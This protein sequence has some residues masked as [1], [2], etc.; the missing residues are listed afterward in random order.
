MELLFTATTPAGAR[1]DLQV[2]VDDGAATGDLAEAL[3]EAL[4][5]QRRPAALSCERLGGAVPT[6]LRLGSAGLLDGDVLSLGD[7]VGDDADRVIESRRDGDLAGY[8]VVRRGRGL[9]RWYE[10]RRGVVV[11]GRAGDADIVLYDPTVS[12]QHLEMTIDATAKA[13]R[14]RVRTRSTSMTSS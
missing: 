4:G 13:G 14:C 1:R 11:V 8:L 3:A 5:W 7:R 9:G 10:L 2:V 12:R 6:S